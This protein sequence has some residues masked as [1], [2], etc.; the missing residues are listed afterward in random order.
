MARR[1]RL[2]VFLEAPIWSYP[3]EPVCDSEALRSIGKIVEELRLDGHISEE[4][5]VAIRKLLK[6]H[7]D[8]S[9]WPYWH[10]AAPIYPPEARF[11]GEDAAPLAK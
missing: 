1:K 4:L 2:N 5:T 6:A 8:A 7:D 9:N 3:E 10:I 11:D